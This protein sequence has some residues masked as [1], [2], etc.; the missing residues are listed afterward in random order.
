MSHATI[1]AKLGVEGPEAYFN[2]PVP[3][4]IDEFFDGNESDG[5]IGCNVVPPPGLTKFRSVLLSFSQRPD[6]HGVWVLVTI[7]DDEKW[8]FSDRVAIASD[9]SD[10]EILRALSDLQP[11]EIIDLDPGVDALLGLDPNSR[12]VSV[13][14]D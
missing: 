9:L 11:D 4:T 5:S 2:P 7:W 12:V 1:A 8:P 10:D 6:V 13:W 3:V 14:W